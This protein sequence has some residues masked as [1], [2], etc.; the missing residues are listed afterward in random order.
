MNTEIFDLGKIGITLG[1]EYDNKVVYEKLT[2]VLYK[3]KSYISTKITHGVSPEQNILVWQLVAEAKDAYD[4]LVAE[5]KTTLTKEEFLEQLVDATKGRYVIQGN[6]VNAADEEDLTV[7]HSDLLGIDTLKLANRNNTDGMGYIILRKNKSFA[8]QVTKEN[9]IYEIR[10]DFNLNSSN[11]IIPNNCILKFE[12]GNLKNGILTGNNTIIIAHRIKIFNIDIQI[13]GTWNINEAYPEWYGAIN[14]NKDIDSGPAFNAIINQTPFTRIVLKPGGEYGTYSIIYL[15][16]KNFEFGTLVSNS[17]NHVVSADAVSTIYGNHEG[18]ILKFKKEESVDG[19]L[20]HGIDVYKRWTFRFRG[21]CIQATDIT[22][23]INNTINNVNCFYGDVGFHVSIKKGVYGGFGY[24]TISD[25]KFYANYYGCIIRSYDW[26]QSTE[27]RRFYWMN[28]NYWESCKFSFNCFGGFRC[29]GAY[30]LENNNFVSCIFESNGKELDEE[31][32]PKYSDNQQRIYGVLMDGCGYGITTFDNCYFEINQYRGT[33]PEEMS[34]AETNEYTSTHLKI[35]ADIINK[36][37]N[38]TIKNSSFNYGITPIVIDGDCYIP[39]NIE[40][41]DFKSGYQHSKT[42]K[43]DYIILIRNNNDANAIKDSRSFINIKTSNL[44]SHWNEQGL[45][46]VLNCPNGDFGWLRMNIDT[47]NFIAKK[48][49]ANSLPLEYKEC[50]I[51]GGPNNLQ[52]NSIPKRGD[53]NPTLPNVSG[54]RG[55]Q[56]YN[57][58]LKK[59]FYWTGDTWTDVFNNKI[60]KTD[61]IKENLY[62]RIGY[63]NITPSKDFS[64]CACRICSIT[65]QS[66][67]NLILFIKYRNDE[68]TT[69]SLSGDDPKNLCSIGISKIIDNKQYIEVKVKGYSL[70]SVEY[71]DVSL[72]FNPELSNV[73]SNGSF[74]ENVNM[75]DKKSNYG[76]TISRP[77]NL[78]EFDTGFTYFDTNIN[79]PI[80][81]TGSK[82]VDSIGNNV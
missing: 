26:T 14:N 4:M 18:P 50:N 2:I 43:S 65:T 54:L 78:N 39:I 58:N 29:V 62:C 16:N 15:K 13:T 8:E 55:F 81:W 11:I 32:Y 46:K 76:N 25:C 71:F 66:F 1:G 12:G 40:N 48:G 41:C 17:S 10:Y 57:T 3:G 74:S 20:I 24:N 36:G 5:G 70:F 49:D 59:P 34:L 69:Y 45:V 47:P 82:W 22:G 21:D 53:V 68:I 28:A 7:E 31:G 67:V 27:N 79:K 73:L 44:G 38:I 35:Q 80:Y 9:T 51:F 72:N 42:Y 19:V 52:F 64:W 23:F 60:L 77:K 63:F 37:A 56:F 75:I 6:L 33:K 30:S 61:G